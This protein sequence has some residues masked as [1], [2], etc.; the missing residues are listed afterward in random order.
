MDKNVTAPCE[1]YG[2]LLPLRPLQKRRCGKQ[3]QS[4]LLQPN[5]EEPSQPQDVRRSI[6][7][8][9]QV[10]LG[11]TS[12]KENIGD[13]KYNLPSSSNSDD[14]TED[15]GAKKRSYDYVLEKIQAI[16][17]GQK[18][19]QA[20]IISYTHL[21][22]RQREQK[23][24]K[25]KQYEG[26][27]AYLR[28]LSQH[29]S[30]SKSP[31]PGKSGSPA[32]TQIQLDVNMSSLL[33]PYQRKFNTE[34]VCKRVFGELPSDDASHCSFDPLRIP[35]TPRVH[36][37]QSC[38][39]QLGEHSKRKQIVRGE[40]ERCSSPPGIVST[41]QRNHGAV[42][43]IPKTYR[44][45]L[46][47]SAE[48]STQPKMNND[49]HH[50]V[51]RLFEDCHIHKIDEHITTTLITSPRGSRKSQRHTYEE[52]GFQTQ[53]QQ[54]I[55]SCHQ[56]VCQHT[57]V[58]HHE[59]CHI[60]LRNDLELPR[61][62]SPNSRDSRKCRRCGYTQE[63]YSI[64]EESRSLQGAADCKTC[65]HHVGQQ[66]VV[67]HHGGCHLHQRDDL[68][69]PRAPSPSH[70]GTRKC[71]RCGCT[72]EECNSSN[73]KSGSLQGPANCKSDYHPPKAHVEIGRSSEQE[74][75]AC[76]PRLSSCTMHGED[77]RE[78][79]DGCEVLHHKDLQRKSCDD[80]HYPI[81]KHPCQDNHTSPTT[82]NTPGY[83][84]Y[85]GPCLP[86]HKCQEPKDPLVWTPR[87]VWKPKP[88]S[89]HWLD[90]ITA[91]QHI[92]SHIVRQYVQGK[93]R[94][95]PRWRKQK[96]DACRDGNVCLGDLCQ[97]E[98]TK[99]AWNSG[100]D[101]AESTIDC[102]EWKER[103][104]KL[105]R[106]ALS[107][108]LIAKPVPKVS[109]SQGI[110][111]RKEFEVCSECRGHKMFRSMGI[112]SGRWSSILETMSSTGLHQEGEVS[113]NCSTKYSCNTIHG[114]S[115]P[116]S[117]RVMDLHSPE[118]NSTF[119]LRRKLKK[120]QSEAFDRRAAMQVAQMEGIEL[121]KEVFDLLPASK[122]SQRG[123]SRRTHNV[124]RR[125]RC[126]VYRGLSKIVDLHMPPC[127]LCSSREVGVQICKRTPSPVGNTWNPR[128][129]CPEVQP[130]L[131]L[132]TPKPT[133]C[134]NWPGQE[135]TICQAPDQSLD[136]QHWAYLVEA[137]RQRRLVHG[138][139]GSCHV[140]TG[141]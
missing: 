138:D 73:Q 32:R 76:A 132:S 113:S 116:G 22:R 96:C 45:T 112:K 123:S 114:L 14:E 71:Q 9:L 70:M 90:R 54:I 92:P 48:R 115:I 27:Q 104:G 57:V 4:P 63:E 133:T 38:T 83:H 136:E 126:E 103:R 3:P 140:C 110:W 37:T 62:L 86:V 65:H 35:P 41:K 49:C 98:V 95:P 111:T 21:C 141:I 43:N 119:R 36:A 94:C 129:F 52:R 134:F 118:L 16:F 15:S 33:Q 106:L 2:G 135:H 59:G 109:T 30:T 56:H 67:R 34:P 51:R 87:R 6:D 85:S 82:V 42:T 40:A 77:C 47:F 29:A 46:D 101:I 102:K 13:L 5:Q 107:R 75:T 137:S 100:S 7:S 28:T 127:Q 50:D 128:D 44:P 19:K 131:Q 26:S 130:G 120:L 79:M 121:D 23:S 124:R 64:N 74:V 18:V 17:A 12:H 93:R 91:S 11:A 88:C 39:H 8:H 125:K 122:T 61:A 80:R 55:Y 1:A 89:I 99:P 68:E 10:E 108:V 66:T 24:N 105:S 81:C 58:R 84:L 72:Q 31:S 25:L 97:L 60:H 69:L 78:K 117:T 20:T 53:P 139:Y